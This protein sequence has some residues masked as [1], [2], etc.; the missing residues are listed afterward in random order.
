MHIDD[1]P[2]YEDLHGGSK[3]RILFDDET[4]NATHVA[5]EYI[6][7]Q[8]GDGVKKCTRIRTANTPS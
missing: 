1:V 4:V 2:V 6:V 3:L 7:Y 5:A 8:P